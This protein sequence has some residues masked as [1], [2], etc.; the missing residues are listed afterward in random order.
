MLPPLTEDRLA[1]SASVAESL[2]R[3]QMLKS[4][5]DARRPKGHFPKKLLGPQ[6]FILDSDIALA[7][8]DQQKSSGMKWE[9]WL[10]QAIN[11]SLRAWLGV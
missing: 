10:N 6:T 7:C 8:E 11:D 5:E 3:T 2:S 9:A 4:S 1:H